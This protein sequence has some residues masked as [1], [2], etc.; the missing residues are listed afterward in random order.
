[1]TSTRQ[2]LV[3]RARNAGIPDAYKMKDSELR[4]ALA[5][6]MTSSLARDTTAL[7]N[8]SRPVI[9]DRDQINATSPPERVIALQALLASLGHYV[10]IDGQWGRQTVAAVQ[11]FQ[12]SID[13]E[14]TGVV[15][16]SLFLAMADEMIIPT[17]EH[18]TTS[19]ISDAD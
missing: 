11:A 19:S 17:L 1:M 2:K 8:I 15:D 4:E 14:Q 3:K 9:H 10:Q 7:A 18:A 13:Q 6:M 5:G 16:R 12:A